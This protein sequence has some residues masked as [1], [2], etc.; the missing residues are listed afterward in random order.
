MGGRIRWHAKI[1]ICNHT[2]THL[3][4]SP[5]SVTF[6][7]IRIIWQNPTG[8]PFHHRAFYP[9]RSLDLSEDVYLCC[10]S[11]QDM[12]RHA[13]KLVLVPSPSPTMFIHHV[14]RDSIP[15]THHGRTASLDI[16]WRLYYRGAHLWGHGVDSSQPL[17]TCWKLTYAHWRVNLSW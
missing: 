17:W 3:L 6:R 11:L 8:Y 15:D 7:R 5:K 16:R 14:S 12:H 9:G 10:P 2:R 1:L 13:N 4:Y